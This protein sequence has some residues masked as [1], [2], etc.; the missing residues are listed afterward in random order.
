MLSL[1]KAKSVRMAFG[2]RSAAVRS[3][4]AVLPTAL[5]AAA[6]YRGISMVLEVGAGDR[7]RRTGRA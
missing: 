4:I 1:E 2:A 6:M 3:P 7:S 5:S